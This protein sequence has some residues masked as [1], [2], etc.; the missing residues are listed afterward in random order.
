VTIPLR[1]RVNEREEKGLLSLNTATHPSH[2]GRGLFTRLANATY[3]EASRHGLGFVIGVANANSTHGFTKKLGF[4]LVSPLK[5]MIGLGPMALCEE[6]DA[7]YE[8]L[9]YEAAL[10]WRLSHPLNRYRVKRSGPL[11]LVLTD[12]VQLGA[13]HVLAALPSGAVPEGSIAAFSGLA[14]FK[15]WIGLDAGMRW[16]GR[17]YIDIPMRFRPSPLNLIF[18]DLTGQGRTLDPRSV[19]FQAIDFDVL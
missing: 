4:Q 8:H 10:R 12:R 18:K 5:A 7:Q 2:Q 14:P 15:L 3:E 6:T 19:R 11:D 1:A 13:R 9:W 16:N 17:P